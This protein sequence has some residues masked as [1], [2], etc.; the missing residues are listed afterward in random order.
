[1]I[2]SPAQAFLSVSLAFKLREK[3]EPRLGV[4]EGFSVSF[5]GLPEIPPER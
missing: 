2:D 4:V 5:V 1:M 3:K